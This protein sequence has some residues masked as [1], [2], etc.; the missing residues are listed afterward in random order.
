MLRGEIKTTSRSLFVPKL[1]DDSDPDKPVARW[2]SPARRKTFEEAQADIDA[3]LTPV[4]QFKPL[5]KKVARLTRER[6]TAKA[7]LAAADNS[8]VTAT[9]TIAEKDAEIV[10]LK[11]RAETAENRARTATKARQNVEGNYTNALST[12]RYMKAWMFVVIAGAVMGW[13]AA[14]DMKWEI[15]PW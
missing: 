14:V 8:L 10:D 7:A 12:V 15:L 13:T 3:I 1:M 5:Q 4:R 2:M 6:D 9:A 11:S